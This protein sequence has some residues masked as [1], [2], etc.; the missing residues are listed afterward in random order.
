MVGLVLMSRAACPRPRLPKVMLLHFC[1]PTACRVGAPLP[2]GRLG[3]GKQVSSNNIGYVNPP[4]RP[5]RPQQTQPRDHRPRRLP[6]RPPV[7]S[8]PLSVH[9]MLTP[10]PAPVPAQNVAGQVSDRGIPALRSPHPT[11]PISGERATVPARSREAAAPNLPAAAALGHPN[12][13]RRR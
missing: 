9:L 10:A 5:R 6:R 12:R 1:C 2:L 13:K 3:E 7:A 8:L 11:L 4:N